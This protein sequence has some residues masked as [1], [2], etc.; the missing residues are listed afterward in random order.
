MSPHHP[1]SVPR[2]AA[3]LSVLVCAARAWACGP[4]FPNQLL[5]RGDEA[6]LWAPVAEFRAEIDRLR[7]AE[8]GTLRAIVPDDDDHARATASNAQADLEAALAENPLPAERRTHL[9]TEYSEM[10]TALRD[11]TAKVQD[12]QEKTC[13]ED[14]SCRDGR[15]Q[16]PDVKIPDGLPPEF[17]TYLAG[18]LA[19]YRKDYPAARAHW[20]SVLALATSDRRYRSTWAAF[21]LGKSWLTE[22]A[23]RAVPYFQQVRAL[24]ADG[25]RDSLGLAAESLGWEARAELNS[26]H[27]EQAID[28]YL[29]HLA[30]GDPT[31]INSVRLT[32]GQT[33]EQPPAVLQRAAHDVTTR[34]VLTAYLIARGGP[35]YASRPADT[36]LG[37]MAGAWLKAIEDARIDNVE[38]AERL[39]WTAYQSGQWQ[40][41]ERWLAR[42]APDDPIAEWL[43]AKL[44]LR[45]GDVDAAT[46]HLA[47]AVRSF[48][49]CETWIDVPDEDD[50]D[51]YDGV[52][53]PA[54]RMLGEQAVLLLARQQYVEAL[55]TLLH[56]RFWMD[57]AYIAERV[58][59]IDE[60]TAYVDEHWPATGAQVQPAEDEYQDAARPVSDEDVSV[61]IRNLLAR[62]LMRAR[63]YAQAQPY[64]P[65]PLRS[66]AHQLAQQLAIGRDRAQPAP[67]R[68]D[69][70]WRAAQITR[71]D[72]LELLGTELDPDWASLHANFALCPPDLARAHRPSSHLNRSTSDEIQRAQA[73]ATA[74]DHRWHYR[75]LAADLAWEAI[76]LLPDQSDETARRLCETGSWLKI[77]DPHAAD[78][79]YKALVRRCGK[80]Q[81][82]READRLRW[83]P[84]L[85][86]DRVT[87]SPA[88]TTP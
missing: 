20:E 11:Y 45:A 31:A 24:A 43:R 85:D 42:G 81:L 51:A 76:A 50:A 56:A 37:R 16:A 83:F 25:F 67:R 27:F 55:A 58:L 82:G 26:G 63:R 52:F 77:H 19:Y 64:F 12:W 15:P 22:D 62:R 3:V 14:S 60:L 70:L 10:R 32:A 47:V 17:S 2:A 21:M 49:E 86:R 13:W 61:S 68:A 53:H 39:A 75:Y 69:A 29:Q 79:F 6:L 59:T 40:S 80:T 4:D 48:P 74:P 33:L 44:L 84:P 88:S 71:Y 72:G 7:A 66:L 73:H 38:G 41:A 1:L 30:T 35:S 87:Q 78:R 23:T 46:T 54:Q 65:P 28:L 5:L 34:Q 18:A 9:L 36:E 8:T 57:A